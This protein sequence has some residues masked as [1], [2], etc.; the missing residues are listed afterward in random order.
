[1]IIA[2]VAVRAAERLVTVHAVD[3]RALRRER[4]AVVSFFAAGADFRRPCPRHLAIA[5][6]L[7]FLG[8]QVRAVTVGHVTR[9]RWEFS[10][11]VDGTRELIR[12]GV[13]WRPDP[14]RIRTDAGDSRHRRHGG[15]NPL[16]VVESR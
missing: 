16:G 8:A 13:V 10:A 4:A 11:T 7:A 12:R 3:T 1:M 5:A 2:L 15:W 14:L 6:V 9:I